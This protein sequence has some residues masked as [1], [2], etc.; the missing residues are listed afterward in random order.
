MVVEVLVAQ[1]DAIEALGQ[2]VALL[3]ADE[4]GVTGIGDDVMDG[5][6]ESELPVGFAKEEGS[7]VAGEGPAAE[8]GDDIPASEAGK[9]EGAGVTVCHCGGSLYMMVDSNITTYKTTS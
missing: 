5:V 8:V 9:G 6:G 1:G 2:H 7:G 3:V 4:E